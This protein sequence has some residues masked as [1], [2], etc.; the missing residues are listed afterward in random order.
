M[1]G[2]ANANGIALTDDTSGIARLLRGPHS[3]R[4]LA[5]TARHARRL[6]LPSQC[7]AQY[8]AMPHGVEAGRDV[9][10]LMSFRQ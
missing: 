2:I 6:R 9:A 1:Y 10:G 7:N 5:A 3:I 8:K 4:P